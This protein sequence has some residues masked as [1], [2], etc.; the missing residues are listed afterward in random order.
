[1]LN[2]AMHPGPGKERRAERTP[3]GF[4][5]PADCGGRGHPRQPGTHTTQP[6]GLRKRPAVAHSLRLGHGWVVS[7]GARAELLTMAWI[8]AWRQGKGLFALES[9]L[10][11]RMT[12]NIKSS[13]NTGSW[14][15]LQ[16]SLWREKKLCV[17]VIIPPPQQ[18]SQRA[19]KQVS[20]KRVPNLLFVLKSRKTP[21]CRIFNN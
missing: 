11:K 19:G 14:A 16:E 3:P 8:A 18:A 12:R 4:S 9:H 10:G 5:R 21:H 15:A 17:K 2:R 13:L 1:M 20:E 7:R 6:S